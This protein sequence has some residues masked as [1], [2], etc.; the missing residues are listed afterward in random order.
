MKLQTDTNKSNIYHL[1]LIYNY[2]II[3]LFFKYSTITALNGIHLG[4]LEVA[5]VGVDVVQHIVG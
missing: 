2:E 1:L 4:D 3:F 5:L